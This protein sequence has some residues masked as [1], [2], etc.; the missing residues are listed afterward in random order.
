LCES[1]LDAEIAYTDGISVTK[2]GK[3]NILQLWYLKSHFFVAVLQCLF[4][5][6]WWA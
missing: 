2:C 6:W 1:I 5:G 3:R 4:F